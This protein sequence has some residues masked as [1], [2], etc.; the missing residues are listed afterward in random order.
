MMTDDIKADGQYVFEA[1]WEVCNKVGGINTVLISKA[2]SMKEYYE[3][4]FLIGPY[5]KDKFETEVIECGPPRELA[6][7]FAE[8]KEKGIVCSYGTWQIRGEPKV[9]LIDFSGIIKD[10]DRIKGI[11]WDN[12]RIDSLYA[13]WDFEEPLLW[14]WAAGMLLEAVEKRLPGK[15]IIGH[16]HEWLAGFGLLY[17]TQSGSKIRTVFDARDDPGTEHRRTGPRLIQPHRDHQSRAGGEVL[18]GHRQVYRR[19]GVCPTS[20]H[21]HHRLRDHRPR[22][23]EDP[24]AQS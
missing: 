17:L 5:F 9:I 20:D 12:F 21:L 2:S 24:R 22:G 10:K 8:V 7:A 11:L 18:R 23:R 15:R 4:Y 1:S 13:H 16:F 6:E 19:T 3:N 14:S